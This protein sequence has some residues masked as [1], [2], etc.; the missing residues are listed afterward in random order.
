MCVC[1]FVEF[2][3]SPLGACVHNELW[4]TLVLIH[5][6]LPRGCNEFMRMCMYVCKCLCECMCDSVQGYPLAKANEIRHAA[7]HPVRSSPNT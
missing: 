2:C 4:L 7:P 1:V 5:Q 3:L 6:T